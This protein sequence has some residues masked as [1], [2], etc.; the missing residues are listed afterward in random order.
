VELARATNVP[1]SARTV[2]S[3]KA[4]RRPPDTTDASHVRTVPTGAGR[5]KLMVR[6]ALVTRTGR[7]AAKVTADAPIAESQ[8]AARKPPWTTPTGL[9]K[10]WSAPIRHTVRPGVVLSRHTIPRVRSQLGGSCN[11][12]AVTVETLPGR[13]AQAGVPAMPVG[14]VWAMPPAPAPPGST[15]TDA[16]LEQLGIDV[17]RGLAMDAPERAHSGH[18]GTAMALAPL[19]H[20]LFTRVMR[21]DPTDPAWPDRDRFVLSNGHASILLYSMLYL[22]GYGLTLDDLRAFRQW[23]SKTPGHPENRHTAGVEVTTGPLGQGFANGVG[24]GIAERFLRSRFGPDVVDHHTFVLCG[25]GCLEEGIS[26]EAA[27]LAGHLGLGRLV[28][29]YDDNHISIDGPTE[30]AYTDDVPGR[31]AAYGWHVEPVG[32]IANDTGALEQ[33]LRRA[34]AVEDRPSLIVLRSHIGWPSP[35]LTDT[36][37]AHGDP[38]GEDEIRQ[39]KE[40]LGLPADQTFWVPDDVLELYRRTIPRG[41]A[42]R[43]EWAARFGSWDG[44]RAAWDAAWAGKGLPGWEAKLPTFE[45]GKELATRRAINAC[46]NA[47]AEVVPGLVSGAADLTGNTGVKIDGAEQQSIEHPGG[48]QVYYGIREHGMGA[49]MTGM[50]HHG[51]VLPV[52]GTFFCFSDYMRGAVRLAAL[53]QAHVVYSWTHDSVGLGQDGPTHQPVEQLASLR[54]MPGLVVVRPA[55]AN[56]CAQAWSLAVDGEA[57]AALVL[58]RQEIPVLAATAARAAEGVRRGGYVLVD[59]PGAG[60]DGPPDLVLVATGSEVHVCVAAA[61]QLLGYGVGAR[62]VSLPCWEWFEDQG[63]G[64]RHSVLPPGIPTLSVEAAASF[65]WDRYADASVAIDTFGAS[66]PGATALAEY[67]FTPEHVVERALALLAVTEEP[68][69]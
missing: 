11:V 25:D 48:R 27:S 51:G 32:E 42:L 1:S 3:T 61:E 58:S 4:T 41:E 22:C 21:H 46:I 59:E 56:E 2:A 36:A 35:H 23:G 24:M 26:H 47:T 7:P 64:Y 45:A 43:A 55:D 68:R 29:V 39:T 18:S 66:A 37:K 5:R 9:A 20:V 53:S 8:H 54:A 13:S 15:P 62:V 31:F 50:A 52:G 14:R 19:A 69:S 67:G 44:D 6:S 12:G 33:A 17:I 30:L 40:I 65:G 49:V 16:D 60:D 63:E 38:F 34:M 57:P 28:Y 10:R